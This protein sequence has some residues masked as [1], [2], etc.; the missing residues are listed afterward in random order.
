M[1]LLPA[2]VACLGAAL[3]GPPP[4]GAPLFRL[5]R[6]LLGEATPILHYFDA[7]G[8]GE[9]IRLAMVDLG[10]TFYDES[11]QKE[12]WYGEL[13]EKWTSDGSVA[14]GQVPR[15][16]IDGIHLVQSHSILRYLARRQGAYAAYSNQQLA[17][18]DVAADGTEDIRKQITTVKYNADLTDDEKKEKIRIW[19]QGADGAASKQSTWFAFLERLFDETSPYV[20]G[21]KAPTH[22]DY[23]LFDLLDTCEANGA[24]PTYLD[25][26]PN[27]V[28]F[29][30]TFRG[31]PK[32]AEYLKTRRPA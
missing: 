30:E 17:R 11:F 16:D 14:F 10:I 1:W 27:I 5:Q 9:A 24:P 29:R 21:T 2:A 13:K 19:F 6:R 4:P 18:I 8:R 7:R 28:K 32:I 31:R 25:G 3:L 20:A 22:A 15:L 26:F 12:Q 23:L